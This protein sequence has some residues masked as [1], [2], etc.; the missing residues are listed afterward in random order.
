MT[1]FDVKRAFDAAFRPI[2]LH[3]LK[4]LSCPGKLYKHIKG[5]FS[6]RVRVMT[7]NIVSI[8]RRVTKSCPQV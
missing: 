4:E 1:T 8:K 3:S 5:Y 2:F 7:T 6:H